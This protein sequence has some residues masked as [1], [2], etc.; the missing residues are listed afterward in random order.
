MELKRSESIHRTRVLNTPS[1]ISEQIRHIAETYSGLSIAST[2]GGMQLIHNTFLDSYKKILGKYKKGEGNGIRWITNIEEECVELVKTFLDLNMQIKHVKNLPPI[3]FAVGKKEV[4]LTI[5]KMEGGKMIQSL[6]ASNEPTYVTYFYSIFEQLWSEGVD[7]QDRIRN[8]AEG[9]AEETDIE[10]ILNPKKGIDNAWKILRS[11]KKE[12]LI[13]CSTSNAFR[14]QLQIG[15]LQLLKGIVEK[16]NVKVRILV[17]ADAEAK[18]TIK[19]ISISNPGIDI[20]SLEEALQTCITIIIVDRK[21]CV[22][23]ESKDDTKEASYDAA[24]ISTCSNSKAIATSYVSIF[25]SLWNQTELFEELKK[26]NRQLANL[27]KQVIAA[28]EQMKTSSNMQKE[29][30]NVAAHELRAPIQPILGLAE[31]L[32]QQNQQPDNK[33]D[34]MYSENYELLNVIIRN[35]KRLQQL[36][37]N[38]LDVTKIENNSMELNKEEF[39]LNKA[40]LESF[41]DFANQLS[42]EQKEN[43][44]LTVALDEGDVLVVADTHRINQVINNLLNNA[45]KFT[46][47]G[48]ITLSTEKEKKYGKEAIVKIQDSGPGIDPDIMPRLYTKFAT[49]SYSGTGLGLFISKSIVETHGGKMWAENNLDGKGA[50]FLFALPIAKN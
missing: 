33:E 26:S 48:Q 7:A 40:V 3:N 49:K 41:T 19:E 42:K 45:F 22:I 30:I 17:P 20:R 37:E 47:Q 32:R 4:N 27:Y 39:I 44:K 8:I 18:L 36:T 2:F 50:T 43:V 6:I 29:F 28:N 34:Q 16:N 25:E 14:R 31:V 13:I 5:E 11:A 10:I 35:A 9:R 38:I 1:Q 12:I 24:E 46:K 15:G 23:V 21:E